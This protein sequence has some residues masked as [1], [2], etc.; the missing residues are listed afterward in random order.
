MI[1]E[2]PSES[3]SGC[4]LDTRKIRYVDEVILELKQT[5]ACLCALGMQ[6]HGVHL[7]ASED[8]RTTEC[9]GGRDNFVSL[10]DVWGPGYTTL[11]DPR[12]N[13]SQTLEVMKEFFDLF[14]RSSR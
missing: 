3:A 6:L 13:P 5:H 14:V 2:T 8:P 12:L 10:D 4:H 11:C 1:S 7:E 9:I